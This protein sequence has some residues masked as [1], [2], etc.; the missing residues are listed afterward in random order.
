MLLVAHASGKETVLTAAIF[1]GQGSQYPRMGQP[2]ERFAEVREVFARA[3]DVLGWDVW[4]LCAC[5]A[6][7]E[8][9]ETSRAQPAIFVLSYALYRLLEDRGWR[10]DIVAG[11]SLGEFT[12][13][14]AAGA[15]SFEDGLRTVAERGKLMAEEAKRKPGMMLAL[16]GACEEELQETIS[17]LRGLGII[18]PANY[19]CPGQ[20]VLALERGLLE[21]ARSTLTPIAKRV[22]ELPVSGGFHSPLME[23]AKKKFSHF[24]TSIPLREPEIPILLNVTLAPS[25]DPAEIKQAL[26]AQMTAPVRWQEAVE[27]MVG[28]GVRTFAEVGP[29]DVLARLVQRIDRRCDVIVTDGGDPQEIVS[30]LRRADGV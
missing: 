10:P 7:A 29:K 23:E 9:N 13:A 30:R 4:K 21:T 5:G 14:T 17:T 28:Q 20:V 16:L 24:L 19:N 27:R 22:V 3:S 25:R 18:A 11:H 2:Y 6:E 12:A 15:L 26:V 8:L 1:P